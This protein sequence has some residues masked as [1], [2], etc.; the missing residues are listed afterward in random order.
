M[1]APVYG[2]N[3]A[4]PRRAL[5]IA[6]IGKLQVKGSES[7][8]PDLGV[9]GLSASELG[10]P[11]IPGRG[12]LAAPEAA[13][14]FAVFEKTGQVEQKIPAIATEKQVVLHQGSLLLI[15]V[16]LVIGVQDFDRGMAA[17]LSQVA[18]ISLRNF[19]RAVH[20]RPPCLSSLE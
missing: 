15:E 4:Q 3:T 11:L 2:D 19:R 5:K 13:R 17:G 12:Q 8:L 9:L 6:G 18:G 14:L 10:A 16:A 7:L 1:A 20:G